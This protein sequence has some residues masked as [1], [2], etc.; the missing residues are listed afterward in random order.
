MTLFFK[1]KSSPLTENEAKI[2][3]NLGQKYKIHPYAAVAVA[4]ADS[5]LGKNLTTPFNLGNVGN[6]DSCPTCQAYT[7]WEQGIEAIFKTLTNEY[8]GKANKLCH[9][10]KG[11][12]KFCPEGATINGGKFYASSLDN[13]DRN[14]NYA[15][16]WLL[17]QE[18]NRDFNFKL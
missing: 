7:S 3:F 4:F 12:W 2:F 17:G 15:A 10:S 5:S 14:S 8:L 1:E 6:T 16:S 18:F 9:L 13:W 11:G